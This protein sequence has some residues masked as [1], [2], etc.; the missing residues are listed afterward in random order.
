MRTTIDQSKNGVTV[1]VTRWVDKDGVLGTSVE[2][3]CQCFGSPTRLHSD[4][5]CPNRKVSRYFDKHLE[6]KF[7]GHW[8]E[9]DL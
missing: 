5:R 2:A 7:A 4:A 6:Q 8:F 3:S 9:S 1:K